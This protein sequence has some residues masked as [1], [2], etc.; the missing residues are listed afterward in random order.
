MYVHICIY[1][2]IYIYTGL[3]QRRDSLVLDPG[4][5]AGESA[6]FPVIRGALQKA[7]DLSSKFLSG[8]KDVSVHKCHD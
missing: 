4:V 1:I 5:R 2:Y 6:E 8:H 7:S 3:R